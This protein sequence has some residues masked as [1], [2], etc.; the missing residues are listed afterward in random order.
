VRRRGPPRKLVAYPLFTRLRPNQAVTFH[1]RGFVGGHPAQDASLQVHHAPVV[2]DRGGGDELESVIDGVERVSGIR[3]DDRPAALP[4]RTGTR[5]HRMKEPPRGGYRFVVF[6]RWRGV[7]EEFDQP[8]AGLV[9][10][11]DAS[12]CDPAVAKRHCKDVTRREFLF[13]RRAFGANVDPRDSAGFESGNE[14]PARNGQLYLQ[15]LGQL[16]EGRPSAEVVD[17]DL[18]QLA[19]ERLTDAVALV[20]KG[21]RCP[22]VR[23][24]GDA[25]VA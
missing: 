17:V 5:V 6:Q 16:L 8:T 10:P 11:H 25:F 13:A 14:L 24:A 18:R 22:L 4:K 7:S 20:V 23:V 9:D 2:T 15:Q 12:E 19:E 3:T 1:R 21:H